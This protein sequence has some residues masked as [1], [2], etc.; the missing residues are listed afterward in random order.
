MRRIAALLAAAL[1]GCESIQSEDIATHGIYADLESDGYG[2]GTTLVSAELRAGGE[3]SNVTVDLGPCDRLAATL[4]GLER[5]MARRDDVLGRVWYE[6]SFA[7]EPAGAP[8][9]VAFLRTDGGGC[10]APGPSAPDSTVTLPAPFSIAA[11][12]AGASLS[13]SAPFAVSWTPATPDPMRLTIAGLCVRAASFA[14]AGGTSSM[15]VPAGALQPVSDPLASCAVELE[16]TRFRTGTV[17]PAFG[18]G[19]RFV[20]RQTRRVT[21]QS[22]P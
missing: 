4:G 14:V 16:L 17:D 1:A 5:T 6:T 13:R 20:A 12:A 7:G 22:V 8:L 9:R 11:P 3:L 21:A 19:G 18:E 2:S 10:T 15:L